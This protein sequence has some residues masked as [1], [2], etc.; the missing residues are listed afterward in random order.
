MAKRLVW[1]LAIALVWGCGGRVGRLVKSDK[2]RDQSPAVS[3][4]EPKQLVVGNTRFAVSLYQHLK[5]KDGNLFFSPYSISVALAMTYAGA[6]GETEKQMARGMSFLLPQSKL[7]PAF[8][9][10]DLGLARRGK[11]AEGR[12]GESFR[13]HVA[14]TLFGQEGYRFLPEFLDVLA[15]NYGAGMR[16]VDFQKHPEAA[17]KAI[18]NWVSKETEDKIKEV[19]A[20]GVLNAL[21][22]LVLTNAIHFDA[23]WEEPFLLHGTEPGPFTLLDGRKVSVEMMHSSLVP[24][25][26]VEGDGYQAVELPYQGREVAMVVVV[27]TEGTFKEFEQSVDDDRLNAILG[28]LEE[29]GFILTMPKFN[30][31]CSFRLADAL[32]AMGMGDAF[33]PGKADLS[34]MD[35]KPG[36]FITEVVHSALVRV[37]EKGTEA[38]AVT[39]GMVAGGAPLSGPPEVVVDRPFIFLIRDVKTGTVL[40]LGRVVDPRG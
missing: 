37:D 15:V 2:A 21:T 20:P 40:F 35:G 36:L 25:G 3:E 22:R 18:N 14:N 32:G 26:Y 27:P 30:F 17:R 24:G 19:I 11:G 10:L 8:N 38:A 39:A 33:T 16:L 29:S 9:A 1:V 7:H 34:G 31:Q 12:E 4:A 6:R 23:K 13:L 5:Q 28:A